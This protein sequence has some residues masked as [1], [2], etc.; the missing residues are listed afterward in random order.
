MSNS[1][2]ILLFG[3]T[4]H[5]KSS[6]INLI[7]GRQIAEVSNRAEACTLSFKSHKFAVNGR[8]YHIWDT[9][10]L[11]EPDMEFNAIEQACDLIRGLTSEG[12]VDL[13]LFCIR[14]PRATATSQA[15]YRLFYEVL[16]KSQVPIAIV[17]T[18]LE[19]EKADMDEW[20]KRNVGGLEKFGLK[21]AG[22]A[23]VTGL[24]THP[25]Y[26]ESQHNIA[27]LLEGRN[28][29]GRFNMPPETWTIGFLRL[30]SR[31]SPPKSESS[32]EGIVQVLKERC[33]MDT[34]AAEELARKLEGG[35]LEE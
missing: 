8:A 14:A 6:V 35:E 12:G 20:W 3:E 10:G 19:Q 9:V 21:A 26:G 11:N 30:F 15:N 5:G 32:M 33:K 24:P 4:G 29:D 16:C 23:C 1:L 17:V 13:L 34:T 31:F 28:S 22:H 7:A 2:N 25:K 18:H 27:R